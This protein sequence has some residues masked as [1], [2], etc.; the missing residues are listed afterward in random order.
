[1]QSIDETP[2]IRE[3]LTKIAS[4]DVIIAPALAEPGGRDEWSPPSCA[5]APTPGGGAISGTK[6]LVPFAEAAS[7][8]LVSLS[9]QNGELLLV[10]VAAD[11]HGLT[12]TRHQT[13][14]A[15][16]LT[17][18]AFDNVSIPADMI[19]ARG[20]EAQR[21]IEAGLNV[22]TVLAAAEAVGNCEKMVLLG[23]EYAA[24]REQFGQKI[25]SFQAVAHPLANLRIQTD[26]LRLLVNEAAWLLDQGKDAEL[27]IAAMKVFANEVVVEMIHAV[28]AVH[29]AIGYTMEY[30]LQLFTRRARAFCLS[31]G[32]TELQT[33]RAAEALGL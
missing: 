22:A 14:G 33:E 1:M 27:E 28:H 8:L 23:A 24:T 21:A 17:K 13:L 16:P 5:F 6:A 18:V 10:R 12:M 32:D 7:E 15:N 26:A 11:A 25:G 2:A 30:D 3:L 4:S 19:L 31:H 20:S 9:D 29:G